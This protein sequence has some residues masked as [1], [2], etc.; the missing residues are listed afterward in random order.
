M[1]IDVASVYVVVAF[2]AAAAL[3]WIGVRRALA[4]AT[5]RALLDIPSDRSSH[6]VPT[7]RGGGLGIVFAIVACIAA[8][9]VRR[10]DV[11]FALPALPILVACALGYADDRKSLP[12]APKM[13]V[14]V[15]AAA[16]AL[17]QATVRSVPVPYAGT[18][19]LGLLAVPL[20]LFWMAGFSNAFNFMDGINGI[21]GLTV[22]VSGLG[23]A[24]AGLLA[25]DER[26]AFLGAVAAGAGA[27]FLPWTFPKARIFM[28]DSGSLPLG[29][30]LAFTAATAA[31]PAS[32]GAAPALPFPASVLLLGP[33]VFDVTFT[34]VRRAREGKPLGQAHNEH[35]Y[36]RLARGLGG[37]APSAWTYAGLAAVTSGLAVAYAGWGDLGRVLSILV[38]PLTLL[39]CAPSV[40]DLEAKRKMT[41]PR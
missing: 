6:A 27:G 38:P 33:Y 29:M 28:G 26:T 37:H 32:P 21:S 1:S 22:L 35:L 12:A 24:A 5:A 3:S 25:G 8:E 9:A 7:P 39:A 16:L 13:L 31:E 20:S 23:F 17:P 2:V 18:V 10:G 4:F 36:Q 14:L 41:P 34:L 15:L 19:D 11:A 40:F 30:L